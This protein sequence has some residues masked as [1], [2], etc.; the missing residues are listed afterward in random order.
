[1]TSTLLLRLRGRVG[2]RERTFLLDADQDRIGSSETNDI[3]VAI[4]GVSRRH[5]RLRRTRESLEIEDLGSRNGTFVN[6]RRVRRTTIC[7]GD[8]IRIGPVELRLEEIDA[9]DAVL[10]L[11]VCDA[12][13]PAQSSIEQSTPSFHKPATD[14]VADLFEG[15]VIPDGHV[16]GRS[17]A[18]LRCYASM[19]PLLDADLP[20]L[21][22]GETG[23]GKESVARMLHLSSGRRTGP[24]VAVNCAAIPSA[25]LEAEMFGIGSGVATGVRQRQGRFREAQTGTLLLDEIGDMPLELQAKLLRALQEKEIQPVGESPLPIDVW[26]LAA[27]NIDLLQ[28]VDRQQFRRDLYYRVAGS[29]LRVPPLRDRGED[30]SLLVE[31]FL[32]QYSAE[33]DKPIRGMTVKALEA[34][35]RY[36]WPGNVRELEHELRRLVHLC[37]PGQ[38]IESSMLPERFLAPG[39]TLSFQP[40]A[41]PRSHGLHRESG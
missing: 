14:H 23:V 35:Q 6:G 11:V 31:N 10:G 17:P 2:P 5:A 15:L 27:T 29:V 13:S 39:P 32:S 34:L 8:L 18:M 33:T 22:E 21:I 41:N 3:L 26:V 37:A 16:P 12:A 20:V 9:S 25:L 4:P 36:P 40:P 19:R 30:V 38:A 7:P 1:M 24:F 28:R